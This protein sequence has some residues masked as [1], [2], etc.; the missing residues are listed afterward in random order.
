MYLFYVYEYTVAALDPITDDFK[1]P[2]GCWELI[3]G[4]L[5]EQS[6]LLTAEPSLQPSQEVSID[7]SSFQGFSLTARC[8][9]I[10]FHSGIFIHNRQPP[11]HPA[12]LCAY[13]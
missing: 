12:F 8:R 3:S 1:P 10:F 5:E 6:V 13:W 11:S 9:F 7:M 2:Y 4:P